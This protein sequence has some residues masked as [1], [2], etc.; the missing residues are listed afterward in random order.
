MHTRKYQQWTEY[1]NTTQGI[2]MCDKEYQGMT[3][4]PGKP[5]Y[6]SEYQEV[7]F[8]EEKEKG[9]FKLHLK[10]YM[11]LLDERNI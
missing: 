6:T 8:S 10:K 4:M 9:L 5:E 2:Q 7:Q 1:K 11:K 3:R